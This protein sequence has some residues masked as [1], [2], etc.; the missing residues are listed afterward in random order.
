MDRQHKGQQQQQLLQRLADE[1]GVLLQLK[2]D[3]TS[4][5]QQGLFWRSP[6][7]TAQQLPQ[8]AARETYQ[9]HAA[10]STVE[11]SSSPVCAQAPGARK[12]SRS[13]ENIGDRDRSHERESGVG[14][15]GEQLVISVPLDLVLSLDISGSCPDA[16]EACRAISPDL[17]WEVQLGALLLWASQPGMICS[18]TTTT[19]TSSG[20]D[21]GGS[22]SNMDGNR[23]AT[24]MGDRGN[25]SGSKTESIQARLHRF[26][27][28][29][30]AAFIPA[31]EQLTSPLL[32]TA[33]QLQQLQVS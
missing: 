27:R 3:T 20:S 9:R 32:F 10:G 16:A 33:D 18:T 14:Q 13:D 25:E 30:A 22:N 31:A 15:G 7:S 1:H 12:H 5:G 6:S 17:A 23:Q 4:N 21:S 26:W 11:E 2:L 8:P 19:T 28:S 24:N 29:Y